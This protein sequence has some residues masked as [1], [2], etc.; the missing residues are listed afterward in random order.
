MQQEEI[1]RFI[2]K[3]KVTRNSMKVDFY[4]GSF[5]VG[6]FTGNQP[7]SNKNEWLFVTNNNS[8]GY[9]K[10]KSDE[11]I[12]TLKGADI[13]SISLLNIISTK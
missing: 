7:N 1:S 4:N 9:Q 12:I 8:V 3:N 5:D 11:Y 13:K 10:T 6:F 2:E